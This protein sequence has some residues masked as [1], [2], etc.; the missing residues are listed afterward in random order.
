M[1]WWSWIIYTTLLTFLVA[2]C[3]AIYKLQCERDPRDEAEERRQRIRQHQQA[4]L[5]RYH[6]MQAR[7]RREREYTA[8]WRSLGIGG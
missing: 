3:W 4:A 8:W 1:N 2:G 7:D 6:N 5:K